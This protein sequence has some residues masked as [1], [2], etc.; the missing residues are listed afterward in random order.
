M[1]GEILI[2]V[3]VVLMLNGIG[4]LYNV[5]GKTLAVFNIF[6]GSLSFILNVIEAARGDYFGAAT[7]LLFGFTY[8]FIAANN[9]FNLDLRLY[10]WY[11]LFVAINTVPLAFID[12]TTL[13]FI[14]FTTG[15][16]YWMIIWLL[17][18]VLWLTGFIELVLKKDLGKF[19]P[20]LSIFDG[21]VTAWIPGA[22]ILLNMYPK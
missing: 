9:I 5:N 16:I 1:L 4:R 11:C 2:Y 14:E 19:T 15:N 17:W 22:L 8:L 3:G 20:Y 21:I 13:R 6:T 12:S 10:G 7:G 18:G